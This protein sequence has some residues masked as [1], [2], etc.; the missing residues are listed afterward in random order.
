M[1][2][3]SLWLG[4]GLLVVSFVFPL[5][6]E[7]QSSSKVTSAV[8]QTVVT[9]QRHPRDNDKKKEME[10]YL[11]GRLYTTTGKKPKAITIENGAMLSIPVNNGV[12]T[13]YVKVGKNQSDTLNFTADGVTVAFVASVEGGVRGLIQDT[14]DLNTGEVQSLR[15]RVVLSRNV[16]EDDTGSLVNRSVQEAF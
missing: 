12:H 5:I 8:S 4:L 14:K 16:L 7:S 10:V 11:D 1:A 13:I 15:T 9:I 6:G 3:K 2:K